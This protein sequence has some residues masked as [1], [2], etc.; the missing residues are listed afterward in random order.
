ML[1]EWGESSMHNNAN[2]FNR[3]Q[4]NEEVEERDKYLNALCQI[5]RVRDYKPLKDI[6]IRGSI[7]TLKN[8]IK[9]R[10]NSISSNN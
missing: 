5:D 4:N 8:E 6:I 7:E 10:N 3:P 2:N 9:R 1:L